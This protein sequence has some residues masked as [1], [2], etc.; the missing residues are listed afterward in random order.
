M[1][2]NSNDAL[3]ASINKLRDENFKQFAS[4]SEKRTKEML[5]RLDGLGKQVNNENQAYMD[6]IKSTITASGKLSASQL[7]ESLQGIKDIEN[8][9]KAQTDIAESDR[10]VLLSAADIA[11]K[12][13]NS[14]T[15]NKILGKIQETISQ[16]AVDITSVV[17]GL[18]GNSPAVMFATKYVLDKRKQ[19][20]EEKQA[21]KKA[22]AEE[23]L[24]RLESLAA[25]KQDNKNSKAEAEVI[26]S[27]SSPSMSSGSDSGMGG[28]SELVVWAELQAEELEKIRIGIDRAFKVDALS[29][30]NDEENRREGVRQQERMIDAIEGI[31]IDGGGKKD[32]EEEGGGLLS[33]LTSL[34]GPAAGGLGGAIG[35]LTGSLLGAGG[36]K[37]VIG[38]LASAAGPIAAVAIGGGMIA[39]D[40]Y[41]MAAAALDNDITTEI[42]GKDMAG[43][44]GGALLGTVGAFVGGPLGAGLGMALGN[45]VGGFIGDQIAPAYQ[46]VLVE[47]QAKIQASKDALSASM[48]TIQQLYDS[49]AISRAEYD[50][51]A[52][53]IQS[54]QLL[55]DQ[56][57]AEAAE[58]ERLNQTRLEKGRQYNDLNAT[59]QRMED[60]GLTVSGSM[61]ATLEQLETQYEATNGAFEEAAAALQAKVD[62]SYWQTISSTVMDTWNSLSD[63][64]AAAFGVMKDSFESA[65]GWFA[66]KIS[67]LD[68]AFGISQAVSD[69][70]AYVEE[71]AAALAESVSDGLAVA[72]EV[73]GDAIAPAIER[74]SEF[75]EAGQEAVSDAVQAGIQA[76][77]LEDEVEFVGD[78]L[79][80]AGEAIQEVGDEISGAIGDMVEGVS[81]W[82][83]SW[84]GDGPEPAP[85]DRGAGLLPSTGSRAEMAVATGDA[86]TRRNALVAQMDASG[87]TSPQER[88]AIMA[89]ADHESG[90]FARTEENFNYSG[91]RL[92]ELYGEGNS[93]GN[94]VRFNSVE[95]AEGLVSQGQSAVGDVIYGGRMGNDTEGDGFKYRGRGAFQL[96]GKANYKKYGDMIGIDL[97]SNPELVNDP[98]IGAK[99]AVAYYQDR[100][101]GRGIAGGDIDAVSRAVNG[102]NVGLGDRRELYSQYLASGVP[103]AEMVP[104]D[105]GSG[106]ALA[107]IATTNEE[108]LAEQQQG[109]GSGSPV[110]MNSNSST[111][112]TSSSNT[113]NSSS[114]TQHLSP[115]EAALMY[116]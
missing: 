112:A 111:V 30:S 114:S 6:A 79:D 25:A 53:V 51:Q 44:I 62:P 85:L 56:H 113:T 37:G 81:S 58:V 67:G 96:T 49:G 16:N 26:G 55:N 86:G 13:I 19:M 27:K 32:K 29:S 5:S 93:Y 104:A 17:S 99:V 11:K 28:V 71:R 60:Q 38:R 63:A 82:W 7:K 108:L 33:G 105:G 45:M 48:T 50:Q 107:Q 15:Q 20:K 23:S 3:S 95:E 80:K 76:M 77:G 74:A 66:E 22:I 92:F 72:G 103:A 24:E 90:G 70:V 83:D 88:A 14:K 65:K 94:R 35:G 91:R 69:S 59:I 116:G 1:A 9:L 87:I 21:R 115:E 110:I 31:K 41:D 4:E 106:A 10:Q 68:E 61:Y 109:T 54:Q 98:E 52:A 40:V 8:V 78:Q 73:V 18:A 2:M 57:A 102:G 36:L 64:G 75:V 47:S 101:S 39:K 84:W 42:E 46:E 97:V 12:Q 100:V 89:Q 34:L 43:A